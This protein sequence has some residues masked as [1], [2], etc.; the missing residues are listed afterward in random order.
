VIEKI[1]IKIKTYNTGDYTNEKDTDNN[2]NKENAGNN[3]IDRIGFSV[4]F[5]GAGFSFLLSLRYLFLAS[6][7]FS[8]VHCF[9]V[10]GDFRL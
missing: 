5:A 7:I 10:G 1:C 9:V 6:S 3:C 4:G 8:S 2:Y